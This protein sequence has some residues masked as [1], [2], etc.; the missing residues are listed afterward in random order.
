MRASQRIIKYGAISLAILLIFTIFTSIIRIGYKLLNSI[1]AVNT[2]KYLLSD[3]VTITNEMDEISSLN[4]KLNG[5]NLKI[6]NGEKFE[7]KT[8]NKKVTYKN[9][10]GNVVIKEKGKTNWFLSNSLGDVDVYLPLELNEL[11]DINIKVAVGEISIDTLN[12]KTLNLDLGVGEV[13]IDHLN[14]SKETK[15]D[16]GTGQININSGQI[17]NAN[18]NLGVGDANIST[19]ILGNGNIKAGIGD[20]NIKSK[21]EEK[22]YTFS[23]DKGLGKI[24]FNG[25]TIGSNREIG[26]GNN[27][28][29]ISGGIGDISIITT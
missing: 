1:G 24:R 14:V 28:I 25:T 13:I 22:E 18:F 23:I 16:G 29:K 9:E 3:M 20:L 17:N 21:L 15:I 7:I 27:Y 4:I 5:T 8:N 11:E 6:K 10:N 2:K 26:N 12:T 19:D